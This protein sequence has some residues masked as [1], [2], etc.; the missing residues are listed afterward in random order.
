MTLKS[1]QSHHNV[2][3]ATANA[4]SVPVDD[5]YALPQ[6]DLLQSFIY[7]LLIP[8]AV[9]SVFGFALQRGRVHEAVIIRQQMLMQ[10]FAMMKM[11]LAASGTSVFVMWIMTQ[12][13]S[14]QAKSNHETFVVSSNQGLLSCIIGGL[15]LGCGMTLSGSC[16]GT[17]YSQIG[18]GSSIAWYILFGGFIAMLLLGTIDSLFPKAFHHFNSIWTLPRHKVYLYSLFGY[19]ESERWIVSVALGTF[20]LGVAI[21]LEAFLPWTKD[22]SNLSGVEV[23]NPW[24]V[25]LPPAVAGILVGLLQIPLVL[26]LSKQLG[27]S[28][29]YC[30]FTSNA[31]WFVE[32]VMFQNCRKTK[33]WW[34]SFLVCGIVIGSFIS[35]NAAG[36]KYVSDSSSS[37]VQSFFGGLLAVMG[38]RLASG[39][40]SGHGIS[41]MGYLATRSVVTVAAMFA[42]G[43]A[44]A[45][46][47]F[48]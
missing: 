30:T 40:T 28:S 22:L 45:F 1:P 37:V 25:A 39:C 4:P 24:V 46:M 27:S 21:A 8:V 26:L 35:S 42:G 12:L 19:Q 38:G 11:F 29:S 7:T 3:N 36:T 44:T 13:G 43:M 16:P 9:G 20:M 41:G 47:F 10:V 23:S 5:T 18:A 14:K 34:Q 48:A 2:D 15:S 6:K 31:L 33:V 32:S 17:V